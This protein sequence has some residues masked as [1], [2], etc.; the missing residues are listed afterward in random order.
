MERT[1][2]V[3][4]LKDLMA[5][6]DSIRFAT[7]VSL[8]STHNNGSWTLNIKWYN[9]D[10]AGCLDKIIHDRGLKATETEDGYTVFCTL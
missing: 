2:A 10:V 5:S 3:S 4:L 1:D 7:V 9:N 8:M 6:C